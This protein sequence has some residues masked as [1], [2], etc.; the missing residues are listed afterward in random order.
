MNQ[1][2]ALIVEEENIN[3]CFL[4]F[5]LK[6]TGR[7]SSVKSIQPHEVIPVLLRNKIDFL[8]LNFPILNLEGLD[9]FREFLSLNLLARLIFITSPEQNE[10]ESLRL[11]GVDYLLAPVDLSEL[12]HILFRMDKHKE[13]Q[14]FQTEHLRHLI[15]LLDTPDVIRL[16]DY[17]GSS[18]LKPDEI[19]FLEEVESVTNVWLRN[20]KNMTFEKDLYLIESYLPARQFLRITRTVIINKKFVSRLD[21]DS[22]TCLLTSGGRVHRLKFS[23]KVLHKLENFKFQM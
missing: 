12:N 9:F 4:N 2:I 3:S 10:F 11:S 23:P 20:G 7:F 1:L 21:K 17:G 14:N 16:P 13:K 19:L 22:N 8:F 6:K 5:Q 15:R 18:Y